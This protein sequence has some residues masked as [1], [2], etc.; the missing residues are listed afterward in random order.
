MFARVSIYEVPVERVGAVAQT[1]GEAIGQI[2]ELSGAQP[3]DL[4]VNG[5]NARTSTMTLWDSRPAMEASRV[6]ASRLRTR[7][8]RAVDGNVVATEEY[9]VGANDLVGAA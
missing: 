4:L 5:E 8:A 6:T 3:P 9:E 1:F 7:P 2:R